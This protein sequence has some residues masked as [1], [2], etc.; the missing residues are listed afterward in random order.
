MRY[1]R[2]GLL[3]VRLAAACA[4]AFGAGEKSATAPRSDLVFA[5][6]SAGRGTCALTAAGAAYCWAN[7]LANGAM[8]TQGTPVAVTGGLSF[9]ALSVGELHTCGVTAAG[10][11]YCWGDNQDGQ[12]GIGSSDVSPHAA[13]EA[14]TGGLSFATMSAGSRHTCGLTSSGGAYCWGDNSFG[15]LGSASFI[16]SSTPVVVAGGRPFTAGG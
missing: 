5:Q 10:V 6:V 1:T 11:A 15:E 2:S 12:L 3:G 8:G 14:V 7:S 9:H 13:P 4:L 16:S